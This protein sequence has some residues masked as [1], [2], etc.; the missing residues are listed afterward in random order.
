MIVIVVA[1]EVLDGI[2]WKEG[3]E[4]V[5]ELSGERFVVRE[6]KGWTFGGFDDLGH[7]ERF[8]RTGDSQ[9]YLML[10]AIE[11]APG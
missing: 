5:I 9:E 7:G 2:P 6:H 11:D 10:F 1:D 8:A 3:F 4:L